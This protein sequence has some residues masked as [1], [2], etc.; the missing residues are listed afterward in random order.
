MRGHIKKYEGKNGTTWMVQYYLGFDENGQKKRST[1]RGFKTK[2]DAEA[3]LSNI[4]K[5]LH[6]GTYTDPSRL[7]LSE[8][9]D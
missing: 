6:E 8:Y 3:F 1:K 7:P 4:T 5:G 2:R 9:L